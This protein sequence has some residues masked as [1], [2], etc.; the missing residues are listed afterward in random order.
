L[1]RDIGDGDHGKVNSKGKVSKGKVGES[2]FGSE[3]VS[4]LIIFLGNAGNRTREPPAP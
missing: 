1:E 4:I 2:I 3:I